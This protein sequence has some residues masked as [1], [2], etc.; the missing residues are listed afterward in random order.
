MKVKEVFVTRENPTEIFSVI[1]KELSTRPNTQVFVETKIYQELRWKRS[2]LNVSS[3]NYH[4]GF[5][6]YKD[7]EDGTGG[8]TWLEL[9]NPKS[10]YKG[11]A[12]G[13][14]IGNCSDYMQL[15]EFH[16]AKIK[17]YVHYLTGFNQLLLIKFKPS[18][19]A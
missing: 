11:I 9:Y 1:E 7:R 2:S 14:F 10:Q 6:Y 12:R 5:H 17:E 8:P 18:S 16:S 3:P 19:K 4:N 13:S 15:V